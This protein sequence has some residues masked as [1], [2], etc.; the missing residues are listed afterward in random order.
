M[1]ASVAMGQPACAFD[2]G[3]ALKRR[4]VAGPAD[5]VS[6]PAEKPDHSGLPASAAQRLCEY[7]R[8]LPDRA[9]PVVQLRS[10][11]ALREIFAE[12]GV[13]LSLGEGASCAKP[14]DAQALERAI[15]L[16]LRYSV[17]TGHPL[18]HNQLYGRADPVAI[19]ADWVVSASNTNSFTFEV[20][21]VYTLVENE[22][23][24]KMASVI[25]GGFAKAHDGLFL[26][27]G[28]LSNLYAMHLAYHRADPDR[29]TRGAAG[30]PRCVA[31]TSDQAHYSFLKA[32]RVIGLGS[33]NL[34]SVRSDDR[35]RIVPEALEEA[36]ERAVAGGGKPFFVGSIA[37]TTV[38][39]AYDPFDRVAEICRRHGLWHHVDGC[40]G[41]GAFLSKTH[42]HLVAGA[43]KADSVAWNPHKMSG[44]ALQCSAFLTQH[45]GLLTKTNGAK[46]AYLFQPDKLHAS[47]DIGDKTIQCGRKAD[48][49]KLWLM[50]KAK[51]DDGMR[52]TVDHC[53][54]LADFMARQIRSDST[55][56][57]QLVFEP[58]CSN[59]CFWYIPRRL[60]PF[61][62][63]RSTE[64]QRATLHKVAPMIKSAMQKEG[65]AM[66]GFQAIN[67]R[68]NF[69]R[70][71]FASAD[72]VQESDIV[73]LMSRMAAIGE[74]ETC[75]IA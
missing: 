32:S 34:I 75:G 11:E 4:R 25:G 12:A 73:Q 46:A 58:A 37:G 51:G 7:I 2:E 56:A 44:A 23:L 63:E 39:G 47:L 22:V 8:S 35:G 27:G 50:W 13:P 15:D 55:G 41:G 70:M 18:F 31:F 3:Q 42:R 14:A 65:D 62:W 59:V 9:E 20:A 24:A 48:A 61:N 66:I 43:E 28:S 74:R 67:G 60:R 57:W 36:I 52:R 54:A 38:L 10:P 69:F 30:G 40:W 1:T 71:V 68:P 19:V 21:P 49:F 26:P 53:F 64:E 5:A 17:R 72:I 45:V 29:A 6:K 33:D 16:A